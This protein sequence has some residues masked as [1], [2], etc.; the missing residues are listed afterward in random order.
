[1]KERRH[2]LSDLDNAS[3]LDLLQDCANSPPNL[4]SEMNLLQKALSRLKSSGVWND[5]DSVQQWLSSTWVCPPK[6]SDMYRPFYQMW[7]T[8]H[9]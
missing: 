6:V 7:G 4:I 8:G 5:N 3:L 1:M 2:G 9:A